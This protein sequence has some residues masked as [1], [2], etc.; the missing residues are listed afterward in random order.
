[1]EKCERGSQL[2]KVVRSSRQR[3][4]HY[5]HELSIVD[6][7]KRYQISALLELG[8]SISE[9]PNKIKCHRATVYR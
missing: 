5:Y 2:L 8:I 4:K 7:G 1:M 9:I 6:Q 3:N